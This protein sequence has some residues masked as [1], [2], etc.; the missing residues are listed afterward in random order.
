MFILN[1]INKSEF[2]I[3]M[4][5]AIVKPGATEKVGPISGYRRLEI[6]ERETAL[7]VMDLGNKK[8]EEY[9]L[10]ET[11]GILFCFEGEEIYSRYEGNG[12]YNITVDYLGNVAIETVNG[13]SMQVKIPELVLTK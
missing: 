2:T 4:D 10:K 9:P 5:V 11:W 1:L 7:E 12:E 8:L 3:Q 6:K 13:S